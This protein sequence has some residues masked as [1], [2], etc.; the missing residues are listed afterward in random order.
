MPTRA[1]AGNLPPVMP[2]DV[3]S[4]EKTRVTL[5]VELHVVVDVSSVISMSNDVVETVIEVVSTSTSSMV[6]DALVLVD[7]VEGEF[8]VVVGLTVKF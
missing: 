8:V 1:I 3:T 7:V 6:N 5:S 4:R 2:F